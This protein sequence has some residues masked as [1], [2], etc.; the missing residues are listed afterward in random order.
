[1]IDEFLNSLY[2]RGIIIGLSKMQQL[3]M[4]QSSER[5]KVRNAIRQAERITRGQEAKVPRDRS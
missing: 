1:M 3:T 5:I 4:V 2:Q